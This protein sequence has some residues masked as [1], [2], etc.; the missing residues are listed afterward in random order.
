MERAAEGRAVQDLRAGDAQARVRVGSQRAAE[1]TPQFEVAT[2]KPSDPNRPGRAFLWRGDRFLTI[3]TTLMS[4]IGFA[5]DVH[6]KQV[7][8]G[9]DWMSS[10]KF[11]IEAKPD[12]PGTPSREQ[13]MWT[14]T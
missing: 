14:P 13:K 9:E 5:Y 12:T 4:L 1:T 3:N 2:I 10:E 7:I 6:E 8:G 11:D